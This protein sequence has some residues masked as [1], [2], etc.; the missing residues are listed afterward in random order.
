MTRRLTVLLAEDEALIRLD[1][2]QMIAGAG[3]RVIEARSGDDALR[4]AGEAPD[5][6][7]TDVEMPGALDGVALAHALRRDLPTLG[8]IVTSG[9]QAVTADA[10][11]PGALFLPKPYR[12]EELLNAL[13]RIAGGGLGGA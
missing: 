5:I 8:I 12:S 10:L 13:A 6:L 11:P 4:L 7:V 3:L 1:A 2:A 9:R